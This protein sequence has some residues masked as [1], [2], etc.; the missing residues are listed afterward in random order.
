LDFEKNKKFFSVFKHYSKWDNNNYN[1]FIIYNQIISI[2]EE[3]QNLN[4]RKKIEINPKDYTSFED[5]D[6]KKLKKR[7]YWENN[8]ERKNNKDI[9]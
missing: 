8:I 5:D 6:E 4:K 7:W 3:T 9:K 1:L 2:N